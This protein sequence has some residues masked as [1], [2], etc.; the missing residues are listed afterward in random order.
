MAA[1]AAVLAATAGVYITPAISEFAKRHPEV[2]VQLTL[3]DR[4]LVMADEAIDVG[5]PLTRPASVRQC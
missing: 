5:I 1:A 3:T 4:P 2:E